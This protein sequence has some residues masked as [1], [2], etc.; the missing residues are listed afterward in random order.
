MRVLMQIISQSALMHLKKYKHKK[1]LI[2]IFKQYHNDV[3][4]FTG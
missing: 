4:L 1:A 3:I 2:M